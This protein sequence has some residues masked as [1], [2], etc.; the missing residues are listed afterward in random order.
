MYIINNDDDNVVNICLNIKIFLREII[1]RVI[2]NSISKN[3]FF[4]LI[5]AFLLRL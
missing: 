5:R 4:D 1:S 2:R 3:Y